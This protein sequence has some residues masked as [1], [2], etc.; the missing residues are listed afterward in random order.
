MLTAVLL[1]KYY[2]RQHFGP[3]YGLPQ[4]VQVAGFALGPVVSGLVFD[5]LQ[6]YNGTFQAFWARSIVGTVLIILARPPVKPG[7]GDNG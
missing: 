1:A 4:A 3:I 7:L 2:G 6:S 5:R